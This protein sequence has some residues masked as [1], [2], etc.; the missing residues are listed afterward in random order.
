MALGDTAYNGES[1]LVAYRSLIKFINETNPAFSIHVGDIWGAN[2]CIRERYEEQRDTFKLFDHPVVYTPGDNEWTDC[3]RVSY[4][5]FEPHTRLELLRDVFFSTSDSQGAKPMQLVRQSAVSPYKRYSENSRWLHENVLFFTLH[6]SGSNNNYV[7]D[8]ETQLREARDRTEANIA[9][10]RDSFRIARESNLPGVVIA[11]H[12]EMFGNENAEGGS[13]SPFAPLIREIQLASDRYQNPILLIHG[14]THEFIID[15]PFVQGEDGTRVL[16]RGN[17]V[18]L[19]VFGSPEIRAV[20]ISVDTN[21][22]HLYGFTP[23]YI[24]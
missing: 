19:E 17:V 12:A 22:P 10:L 23:L 4:G 24:E 13:R 15:R 9:W 21:S 1:D 8:D 7:F 16:P 18:R 2:L 14:D 20:K 5:G 6:I 11:F 3:S